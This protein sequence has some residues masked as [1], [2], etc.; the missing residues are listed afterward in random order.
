MY[1]EINGAQKLSSWLVVK[2]LAKQFNLDVN[3]DVYA[4]P[5]ID[6]KVFGERQNNLEFIHAMSDFETKVNT[7]KAETDKK[8]EITKAIADY[9]NVIELINKG[10]FKNPVV[11]AFFANFYERKAEF[12]QLYNKYK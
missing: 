1:E 6:S 2:S 9:S 3:K 7:L 11:K 8:P 10:D 4:H 12:D 5:E